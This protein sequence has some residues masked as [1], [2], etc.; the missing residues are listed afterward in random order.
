MA[1]VMDI[2]DENFQQEVVDADGTVLLDFYATWCGPCK[3]IAPIVEEMAQE[4]ADQGLKV[5]KVDIDVAQ[6][7]AT[8]F[9]VRGVPTLMFFKNGEKV[10]Q[11]VGAQPRPAI[12]KKVK[13]LL[14]PS[15]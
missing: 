14:N 8:Q 6:K 2:T 15:S 5:G 4:F 7:L 13:E 11:M 3:T 10:D 9:G 1:D 12:E